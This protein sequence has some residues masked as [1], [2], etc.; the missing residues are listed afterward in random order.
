MKILV[1]GGSYF[2]G[3]AFVELAGEKHEL[4]VI[5]RGS[6]PLHRDGVKEY[7]MDRHDG[8]SLAAIEETHFD[9]IA[10]FCAYREGDIRSL[11]EHLKASFEQYIF[12]STCDVYR[13]GTR[14]E[15]REEG[16]LEERDF[17]GEAGAYILGKAALERELRDCCA[18]RGAAYTSIRPAFIY[19]PGNYAPREEIYFRWITSAGQILHPAD[20]TGRFQMVYVWDVARAMLAACGNSAAYNKAYNLCN[21]E[22]MTYESFAL[23]LQETVDIPFEKVEISVEDVVSRGI[24]LP[25][26]L[27][28]QESERYNGERVAE[29]G[30]T[31][32]PVRQGMAETFREYQSRD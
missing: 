12:V 9:V 17:G 24:G 18:D 5:N 11:T 8:K 20:A 2:L 32:T 25:F 26:P 7:F 19:G 28:D 16:E 10:D 22:S 4:H 13:W 30:V 15:I 23:L 31:Y 27:T 21:A 29:L 14:T 3:K 1:I 6:R